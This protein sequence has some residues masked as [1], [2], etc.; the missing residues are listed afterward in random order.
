MTDYAEDLKTGLANAGVRRELVKQ[1]L[2]LCR[3]GRDDDLA[4]FLK[5]RRCELI[6]KMHESQRRVDVLD[7]LIRQ[8]KTKRN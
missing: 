5:A 7:Y 8:T 1:A 4:R 3:E 2:A 6:E